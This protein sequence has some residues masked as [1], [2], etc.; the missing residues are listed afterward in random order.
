MPNKTNKPPRT[1]RMP[2]T[3]PEIDCL[4]WRFGG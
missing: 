2:S 4:S 3:R 1:P